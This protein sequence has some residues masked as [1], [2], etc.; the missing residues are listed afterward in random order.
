MSQALQ[1]I[2]CAEFVRRGARELFKIE[3]TPHPPTVFFDVEGARHDSPV[4]TTFPLYALSIP[5][6][7]FLYPNVVLPAPD[8]LLDSNLGFTSTEMCDHFI[9]DYPIEAILHFTG[10]QF[11]LRHTEFDEYALPA[12]GA[13][14][15]LCAIPN[16][17]AWLLGEL[18]R[19]LLSRERI[20]NARVI[21]HGPVQPFHLD[22]L[23][24]AGVADSDIIQ[25][26][27]TTAVVGSNVTWVTPT[28]FHHM[29][30]PEAVA[31]LRNRQRRR[32]PG[33]RRDHVRHAARQ[34][35]HEGDVRPRARP[36]ARGQADQPRDRVQHR[37]HQRR[38]RAAGLV[39]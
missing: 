36:H 27:P 18:P 9:A 17:S 11:T 26:P 15:Y 19:L 30:H 35:V 37:P 1:P 24:E 14:T 23:R 5:A 33:S 3:A 39:R 34:G 32:H 12:G 2:D 29:P 7:R 8:V 22:S 31:L 13:W 21:L 38:R 4:D 28:F 6:A 25:V 16:Y 10:P 20:G